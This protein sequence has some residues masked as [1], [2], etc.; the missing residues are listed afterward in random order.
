MQSYYFKEQFHNEEMEDFLNFVYTNI[1]NAVNPR[2]NI[3]DW[4]LDRENKNKYFKTL[5]TMNSYI[6]FRVRRKIEEFD[7]ALNPFCNSEIA[8]NNYGFVVGGFLCNDCNGF[9]LYDKEKNITMRTIREKDGFVINLQIVTDAPYVINIYHY[10]DRH[11]EELAFEHYNELGLSRIEYN[12][13]NN[14]F[15]ECYGEKHLAT[16]K[17]KKFVLENLEYYINLANNIFKDHL[18]KSFN[19]KVKKKL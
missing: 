9:S 1:L 2:I 11:G 13:T 19:E 3:Y 6:N 14:T 8:I 4:M 10:Y 17:D 18:S 16:T 5:L 15:G 12:L 7:N